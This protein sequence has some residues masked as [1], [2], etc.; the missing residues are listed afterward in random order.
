[1]SY[2]ILIFQINPSSYQGT[3]SKRDMPQFCFRHFF[4]HFF[5]AGIAV[6]RLG[7]LSNRDHNIDMQYHL[8]ITGTVVIDERGDSKPDYSLEIL[9]NGQ[10]VKLFD[11]LAATESLHPVK[12][13]NIPWKGG[14]SQAPSDSPPCGW[15]QELCPDST[16][17]STEEVLYNLIREYNI[18]P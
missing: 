18:L 2:L 7:I 14:H 9:S 12:T 8:G 15:D 11:Y 4:R 13:E 1:M 3:Q 10:W 17:E 5:F 16:G 6:Y